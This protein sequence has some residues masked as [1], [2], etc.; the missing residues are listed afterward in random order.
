MRAS[1]AY[2]FV[3]GGFGALLPYNTLYYLARG[4]GYAQIGFILAVGP[5]VGLL[6]SPV[7]GAL[8]DRFG[9]SPR[10]LLGAATSAVV[11]VLVLALA[12]DVPTIVAA[13]VL[14]GT[15]TAGLLPIVDARAL[16]AAGSER[17]AFGRTRAWGSAGWVV[18][19]LGTGVAIQ[20]FGLGIM[21]VLVAG[22]LT[23]TAILGL[24]LAPAVPTRAVV[25]LRATLAIFRSRSMLLFLV[26]ML[27][28][29]MAMTGTINFLALRFGELR[30]EAGIVGAAHALAAGVEVPVM[31]LF[32]RLARRFGSSRMLVVGL[33]VLV[34]R[35]AGAALATDPVVLL[36]SHG[37]GG[38]GYA[39]FTIG[40]VTYVAEHVPRELV[41][42]GQGVFQGFSMSLS[43]VIA[44]ASGGVLAGALGISGMYWVAVTVGL[45]GALTVAVAVQPRWAS[46]AALREEGPARETIRP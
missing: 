28:A 9:G 26:G 32:P 46:A 25:S 8:S 41:A 17:A 12:T 11:G 43:Q 3:Y 36:L 13:C 2:F 30:A 39:F 21:F 37:L 40:G 20:A 23:A 27:F 4:V 10:V 33:L 29:S 15:G 5:L 19:S 6:A 45:L 42:T 24:G 18:F 1:L 16:D 44:A 34:L 31:F 14:I 35:E 38:V 22:G 7:W